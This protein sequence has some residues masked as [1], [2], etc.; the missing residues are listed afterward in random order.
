[1][2]VIKKDV[3]DRLSSLRA[4]ID[5]IDAQI[6]H[7]INKRLQIGK[8][9]GLIKDEKGA[10]VL[11]QGREKRLLERLARLNGG[12]ATEDL[13]RYLF[14]VIMT[15]TREIQK[16][17]R[18]SFLGPVASYTHIAA[19]NLFSHSGRF[20]EQGSIRDIF[21][22]IEKKNCNYGVVPVE[23]SMEGAVNHTLDLFSEFDVSITAEH[24]QRISHDLLSLSG[25]IA[26]IKT[27]Y[28][29]PQALAQCRGWL[30]K[31]MPGIETR[32]VSSTSRAAA[33]VADNPQGAAV[34]SRRAA[35]IYGLK[36]VASR[37]E[38][39]VSNITR[40]L[41]I[42]GEKKQ[43]TGNDKTSIMFA[44]SHVPGA[45]FM[46]LE[47][48]KLAGLNMVKL[49]SRPTRHQ[50]W[51]YY[52]FMDFEGH[53]ADKNVFDTVAKMKPHCLYLKNLGSYP[54]G[55]PAVEDYEK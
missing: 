23:N 25:D 36:V 51:S 8:E 20:I 35:H 50:N 11:D 26:S 18:I 31:N 17:N 52:F 46:A 53:M 41:S 47:P 3:E 45:L 1:M 2:D 32:E 28:S 40:F 55:Q 14:N 42:G 38:D 24:Y 37:I 30:R 16:A 12:P 43:P 19:L 4:G 34:A 33:L 39:H 6:L 44:T 54:A 27:I 9:I 5:S 7:L 15:A 13:V 48:V 21:M 22:E 49:E 10:G 29:H